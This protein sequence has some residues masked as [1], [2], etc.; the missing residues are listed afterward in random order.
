MG[1]EIQ[2]QNIIAMVVWQVFVLIFDLQEG[3]WVLGLGF[4]F[5]FY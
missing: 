1:K 2:K 3:V 5:G 4:G